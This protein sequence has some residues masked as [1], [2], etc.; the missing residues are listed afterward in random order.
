LTVPSPSGRYVH[1]RA[2]ERV[3]HRP[4][5]LWER[6]RERAG[7]RFLRAPL[8]LTLSPKGGE[9]TLLNTFDKNCN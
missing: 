8:S 1:T 4:L 5:S 7:M 3:K 6:A 9:G 2:R